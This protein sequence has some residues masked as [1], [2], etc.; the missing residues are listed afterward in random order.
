MPRLRVATVWF[1]GCSGCH[2]SFLDLDERL[3]EFAERAELVFSPLVD[4]KEFPDDVDVV[5]IEGAVGNTEH[6]HTLLEIRKKA[7][8]LVAFGDC[9]VTGNVPSLRNPIP[10]EEVLQAVYGP[11]DPPGLEEGEVP[12]LLPQALPLHA[13]VPVDLFL[14]GCP[15]SAD[16]IW[17]FLRPLLHG[18]TPAL[19]ASERKFG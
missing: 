12:K 7:K 10:R 19:P 17:A 16:R 4:P 3:L 14:P 13:V 1:S 6:L 11:E 18:Q 5:L 9:A 8:V 2:M 15:P